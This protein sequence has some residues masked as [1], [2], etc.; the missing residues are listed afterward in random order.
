MHDNSL[1]VRQTVGA[2]FDA[3][4]AHDPE[5]WAQ[6]FAPDAV[7]SD[8][9]GTPPTQGREA[10]KNNLVGL[11]GMVSELT[12]QQE[13]V[14]ICANMAA[15]KWTA[16]GVGKNGNAFTFEGIDTFEL[17]DMNRIKNIAAYWDPAPLMARLQK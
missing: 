5:A 9:V 8:P 15:V 13:S 14:F 11:L 3:L 2:Y 17:D 10:I 6:T 16:R 12:F 1:E 7:A 4:N